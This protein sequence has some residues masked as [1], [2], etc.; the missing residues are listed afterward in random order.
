MVSCCD[1]VSDGSCN[2]AF[3]GGKWMLVLLGGLHWHALGLMG[4]EVD[5][6]SR[7]GWMKGSGMLRGKKLE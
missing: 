5:D 3:D 2:A 1:T 4:Y 6:V 7:L